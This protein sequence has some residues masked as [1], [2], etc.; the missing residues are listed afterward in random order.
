MHFLNLTGLSFHKSSCYSENLW[1]FHKLPIY[2]HTQIVNTYKYVCMYISYRRFFYIFYQ[3]IKCGR[4]EV[5]GPEFRTHTHI[6]KL[7][8]TLDKKSKQCLVHLCECS[9]KERMDEDNMWRTTLNT[10]VDYYYH[11]LWICY[12]SHCCYYTN[13][14]GENCYSVVDYHLLVAVGS[15]YS[16]MMMMHILRFHHHLQ[17][18]IL[19]V[20]DL[21]GNVLVAADL[22]NRNVH[23]V[24]CR[25]DVVHRLYPH[26]R[27]H[28]LKIINRFINKFISSF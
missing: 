22:M 28:Y 3:I 20:V 12:Y 10:F 5:K 27:I 13:C 8:N 15:F 2:I 21:V 11:L 7:M 25:D 17:P 26:H 19:F 14:F 24:D 6:K 16:G 1:Y 18:L 9:S 4:F 23:L